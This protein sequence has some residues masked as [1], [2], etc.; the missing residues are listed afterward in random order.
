MKILA[1]CHTCARLHEMDFD[2]TVGPGSGFSDWL[3]KHG[4]GHDT[5]FIYPQRSGKDK[6]VN[7]NWMDYLH[8]ADIKTAY[9]ASVA[10]TITL[11]SL[12]ASATFLAGRESTAID[13]GVNKYL[14]Y[15]IAGKF[16]QAATNTAAGFINVGVVGDI[17]DTPL[18]PDVFDGTDSTE[19]VATTDIYNKVV[20][21]ADVIATTATA[22]A[23]YWFGPIGLAWLFNGVVPDQFVFFISHTAQTSTNAWHATESDH[24]IWYTPV[25][26]TV[27]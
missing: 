3:T 16:R 20:K 15:M 9:G 14:D 7:H 19:T 10:A 24:G 1:L 11:A 12:A 5:N 18:W 27:I 23:Q 6:P 21:L 4:P 26:T 25:Y 17:N 8:N 13:N 2:P 22:S